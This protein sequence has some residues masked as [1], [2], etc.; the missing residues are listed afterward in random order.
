MARL[1]PFHAIQKAYKLMSE[2]YAAVKA[3]KKMW[4]L[5]QYL[6]TELNAWMELF[7]FKIKDNLIFYFAK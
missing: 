1:I 6:L 4:F 2:Q 7:L 3:A 5:T